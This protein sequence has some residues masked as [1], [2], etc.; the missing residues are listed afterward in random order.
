MRQV[1]KGAGDEEEDTKQSTLSNDS[2]TYGV[3]WLEEV[4]N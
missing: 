2:Y 1:C 4:K 3:C